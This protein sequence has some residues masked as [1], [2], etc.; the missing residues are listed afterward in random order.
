MVYQAGS[1]ENAADGIAIPTSNDILLG[2]G[3]RFNDHVGNQ[4]YLHMVKQLKRAYVLSPKHKKGTF[5]LIIVKMIKQM[6]P[7]GRFLQQDCVSML[8]YEVSFKKAIN[9]TRQSLRDGAAKIMK[10]IEEEEEEE[11]GSSVQEKVEAENE[12]HDA[13]YTSSD[14]TAHHAVRCTSMPR[15]HTIVNAEHQDVVQSNMQLNSPN[16]LHQSFDARYEQSIRTLR[17]LK[18]NS[19]LQYGHLPDFVGRDL[20]SR[21]EYQNSRPL[22]LGGAGGRADVRNVPQEA[23]RSSLLRSNLL[24]LALVEA[25]IAEEHARINFIRAKMQNEIKD[26]TRGSMPTVTR[27]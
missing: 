26:H 8:W 25:K 27:S 13:R 3:S 19:L 6:S 15:K 23:V 9:R 5:P 2:R 1:H 10:E 11:E 4:N 17:R 16:L 7:P 12:E 24:R 21:L 18:N 14:Q 22:W 20:P